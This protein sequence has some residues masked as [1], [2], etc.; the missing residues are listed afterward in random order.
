MLLYRT[1]LKAFSAGKLAKSLGNRNFKGYLWEIG[2]V[3]KRPG[4]DAIS[5]QLGFGQV[6]LSEGEREARLGRVQRTND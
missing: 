4:A 3:P 6:G 5:S 2:K 1:M